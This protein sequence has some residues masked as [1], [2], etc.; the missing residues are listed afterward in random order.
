MSAKLVAVIGVAALGFG[1]CR[2]DSVGG[3][4][5]PAKDWKGGAAAGSALP[6]ATPGAMPGAGA[7]PHAGMDIS[8][9][10]PGGADPHAGMDISGGLP[11]GGGG[12][13]AAP[14]GDPT[15]VIRGTV[16]LSPALKDKIAM[17]AVIFV[18]AKRPDPA[19]PE[20]QRMPVAS[21]RIDSFAPGATFE[22]SEASAMATPGA[23]VGDLVVSARFSQTGDVMD[24]KAGDYIGSVKVTA[25]ASGIVITIDT[26]V[27]P[28]ATPAMPP[29]GGGTM[30]GSMGGAMPGHP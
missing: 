21:A 17:G 11:G 4:L 24:R 20:G 27:T 22:L 8:G 16:Q 12:M 7:D 14:A 29:M 3:G 9:G 19:D 30:G 23:L 18:Y 15:H 6:P 28:R 25:P 5:P 1:A 2:K 26:P 10:L 13:A